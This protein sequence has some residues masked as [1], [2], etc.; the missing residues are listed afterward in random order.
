MWTWEGNVSTSAGYIDLNCFAL[1]FD[2]FPTSA[3]RYEMT[4]SR[5]GV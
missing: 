2:S 5:G 3:V 1:L 4:D